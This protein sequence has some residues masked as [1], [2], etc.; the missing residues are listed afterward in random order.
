MLSGEME[1]WFSMIKV[2]LIVI[3]IIVGLVYDWGG[4]VGHPGPVRLIS[5]ILMFMGKL[6]LCRDSLTSEE[7][8]LFLASLS[9]HRLSYSHSSPTVASSSWPSPLEN[10]SNRIG[11]CRERSRRRS[12]GSCY[13]ISSQCLCWVYVST[14][15][16]P[17]LRTVCFRSPF[18]F[19]TRD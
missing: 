10:P 7:D 3:F 9:L 6:N 1:Y 4:V 8:R 17:L 18:A 19:A 15:M 11:A 16:T 13:S 12:S 5:P 14:G 2:V